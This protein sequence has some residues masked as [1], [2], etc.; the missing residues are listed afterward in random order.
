[1][2]EALPF[3]YLTHYR[4][5]A[6]L[7]AGGMGEVYLAEDTRLDRRVAIKVLPA[8]FTTDVDRVRRFMMEAKASSAL[9]HPH[10]ITVHD[11][12]ESTAGRFLVMEAVDGRTVR[13][14]LADGCS[15]VEMVELGAQMAKGLAAAHAAGIVHRDIKPENIMVRHDGYVKILDF[16]L[17]R[18]APAMPKEGGAALPA[19]SGTEPGMMMGTLKYMAPEQARGESAGPA[20]DVYALGMVFFE[21]ATGKYPYPAQSFIGFLNAIVNQPAG[22]PSKWNPQLPQTLDNLIT[23]MLHKDADQ[24]PTAAEVA[25]ALA[26]ERSGSSA[27]GALPIITATVQQAP[28]HTVGRKR[29]LQ[30]L[31][32][33]LQVAGAGRGMLLCVTGEPGIGKSTL[34]EEFLGGV[35]ADGLCTVARGRCSERLAGTEAYLPLLGALES[36]LQSGA[37]AG[38]SQSMKTIAP[39]WHS[40]VASISSTDSDAGAPIAASQDRLKR[41]LGAFLQEAGTVRPVLLFLDDIHWA[42]VST[43]DMLTYLASQFAGARV[44]IVTTYRPSDMLL[45]KHPF[46]AIKPDL[47]ARGLLRELPLA[48]LPESDI[49]QYLQLEFPGHRFPAGFPALIHSKTEG[50]PLFMADLVRYLRDRAVISTDSGAWMLGRALPE[51]ERDLPESVRGMIERKISQL[52]EEDHKLLSVASVQGYEFDSAVVAELLKIEPDEVEERLERLERVYSFVKLLREAEFPNRKIT[53]RYRFIHVLYQ[54]AL[55]TALRATRRATLSREVAQVLETCWGAK[56]ATVANELA[57]LW[58]A[59]RE[60]NK[61]AVYFGQAARQAGKVF[62]DQEAATLAKRGLDCLAQT[63]ESPERTDHE[64][65][66]L[67]LLGVALRAVKGFSDPS[68]GETFLRARELCA[69]TAMSPRMMPVLRG[70]WEYYEVQSDYEKALPYAR[71]LVELS[72]QLGDAGMIVAACDAMG[73]TSVWLGEFET[74]WEHLRKGTALYDA[75]VHRSHLYLYGYDTGMACHTYGAIALWNLGYEREALENFAQAEEIGRRLAHPLT[76][77]FVGIM[78]AWLHRLRGDMAAAL[79]QG[80]LAV[81]TSTEHGLPFFLGFGLITRGWAKAGLGQIDAGIAD[82]QEGMRVYQETGSRLGNS[83]WM[84]CLAEAYGAA[85]RNKEALETLEEALRFVE[86]TGERVY[87]AE[88]LRMKG[89]LLANPAYV[90]AAAAVARRQRARSLELR[91]RASLARL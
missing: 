72:A 20:S 37:H 42:D 90:E 81:S 30:E 71:Q 43:V 62:A 56:S 57:V 10:I 31:R 69:A 34:V 9:N 84:G 70:L 67:V 65:A 36:L 23:R 41:E 16:G 4:I 27:S 28:R 76:T 17:A 68:V 46:L 83:L 63:P 13:N 87:E 25:G 77:A 54:N 39:A 50:S 60:Y 15:T 1:M 44:L 79:V 73:D 88:L 64:L 6:R 91:A 89:I 2:D 61:A 47:Q 40:Q 3:D 11:I 24:R 5:L 7:G 22:P 75:Q 14:M 53:L 66:L 80:E 32:A 38:L 59:A 48:F 86:E 78:G 8:A 52:G 49:G 74:A 19:G 18:L 82:I 26:M 55:F 45:A 58:E 35:A 85:G 29:E 21:M 51:I 12:G 33:A